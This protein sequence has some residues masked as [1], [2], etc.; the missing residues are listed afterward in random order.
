MDCNIILSDSIA[1][2][3]QLFGVALYNSLI[4]SNERLANQA[5]FVIDKNSIRFNSKCRQQENH[6]QSVAA[7]ESLFHLSYESMRDSSERRGRG[8]RANRF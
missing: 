2:A 8:L 4:K 1:Y 3:A 6:F 7:A 5:S